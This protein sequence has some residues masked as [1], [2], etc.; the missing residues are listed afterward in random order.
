MNFDQDLMILIIKMMIPC[1][2]LALVS[3]N[4]PCRTESSMMRL[5]A[6][7]KQ[8]SIPMHSVIKSSDKLDERHDAFTKLNFKGTDGT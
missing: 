3:A 6:I 4:L 7:V 5:M 2:G 1:A 8:A